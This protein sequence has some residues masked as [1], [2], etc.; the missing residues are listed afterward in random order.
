MIIYRA[1]SKANFLMS[2]TG[3]TYSES[4]GR[5][6]MLGQ[7]VLYTANSSVTAFSE[8]GYYSLIGKLD[9]IDIDKVNRGIA[10]KNTYELLTKPYEFTIGKINLNESIKILD[11]SDKDTFRNILNN[12]SFPKYELEDARKKTLNDWTRKIGFYIEQ[13]GYDGLV[14]ESARSNHSKITVIFK[15]G[16]KYLELLEHSQFKLY[17]ADINSNK[18]KKGSVLDKKKAFYDCPINGNGIV[19]ILSF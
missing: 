10:N 13:I 17:Y 19:D 16:L 11:L 3:P 18:Y 6:N 1:T 4:P 15:S 8:R 5:W 9:P 12:L 14:F 2:S 7:E